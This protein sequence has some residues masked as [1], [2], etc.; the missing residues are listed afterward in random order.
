[1]P[2]TEFSL[3]YNDLSKIPH[4]FHAFKYN[5]CNNTSWN[6]LVKNCLTA[7]RLHAQIFRELPN[8]G[9]NN[10]RINMYLN[11]L[12]REQLPNT[13]LENEDITKDPHITDITEL[14]ALRLLKNQR[15]HAVFPYPRVLHKEVPDLQHHG[16]DL[17][18][19]EETEN[20]YNLLIVEVMASVSKAQPP[21]TVNQHFNQLLDT[22]SPD[23]PKRLVDDLI[24]IHDES[25]DTETKDILNGFLTA[26][27][28]GKLNKKEGQ[29]AL[30]VLVRP[31]SLCS[32][33]DWEPFIKNT[34]KFENTKIPAV[35]W[36]GLIE[37]DCKFSDIMNKIK[38]TVTSSTT[39]IE[40]KN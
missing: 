33:N 25:L 1:M 32:Q 13:P 38:S 40:E 18:G 8:T 37:C 17:I 26:I 28:E 3:L 4:E 12:G 15:P 14:I 7:W 2:S 23:F 30:A 39:S 31:C 5:S 9:F 11:S 16:I 20:G 21:S 35:V 34:H 24:F 36:F 29:I 27:I 19:F 6:E 22:L 10:N